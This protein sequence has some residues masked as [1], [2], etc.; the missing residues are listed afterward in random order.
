MRLTCP[1]CEAQYEVPDEV[2]PV[3]GRDV[4]CSNCGDTWFQHHPDHTPEPEEI[5]EA[6]VWDAPEPESPAPTSEPEPA[7]DAPE[8]D[9]E[10]PSPEPSEEPTRR[11]LDPA[12]T[13]V[14]REEADR[15]RAARQ[16]D[17]GGLETQTEMGLDARP[18]EAE[19]RSREAQSRMARLRGESEED[20]SEEADETP[21]LSPGTRRNLLP[22]IDE[23]NSS[24]NSAEADRAAPTDTTDVDAIVTEKS[25]G[26]RRGFLMMILLAVLLLL[27]YIYAPKLAA[28]VPALE[29]VLAAYVG[30]VNE[31]RGALNAML[32]R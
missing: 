2:I 32:G 11:E 29:G 6:E 16:K 3:S 17:A 23:I 22:D 1:N 28:M 15:E 13:D 24:L 14:L 31:A 30:L 7:E 9:A 25:G 4:Q 19:R 21:D 27:L 26:F 20:D 18:D 5:E 10:P 12:V 8:D